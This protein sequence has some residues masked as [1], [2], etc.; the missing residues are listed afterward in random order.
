M[1]YI[2]TL[3]RAL[4][5]TGFQEEFDAFQ[6]V[7]CCAWCNR[8][9]I[10]GVEWSD[11]IPGAALIGRTALFWTCCEDCDI[12]VKRAIEEWSWEGKAREVVRRVQGAS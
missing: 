10:D 1:N 6:H 12:E 9:S 11:R 8:V 4:R 2:E 7:A 3:E 5:R